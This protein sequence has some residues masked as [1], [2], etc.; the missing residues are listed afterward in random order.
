VGSLRYRVTFRGPGG[1]SWG[2]FGLANPHNALAG[3]IRHF[4]AAADAHTR[5]GPRTSYNVGRIGGGTSVNSIPFE[6]WM[7]VDMRS[8]DPA[9]LAVLDSDLQEG[10]GR[11][12][13]EENA[14]RR[15]GDSLTVQVEPVGSR[16]AGIL[17]P[18]ATPL[19]QR[20]LAVIRLR[21]REP[22]LG[23]GSTNANIPISLGVPAVGIG[24]GG[25]GG[26]NHSLDEWWLPVDAHLAVQNALLVV[27]AEGGLGG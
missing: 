15:R 25:R 7:E 16:P 27:L 13:M 12:L 9:S 5:Q 3:A 19:I 1:H 11:G 20:A 17:D 26:G 21:G 6:S 23:S 24:R 10:I 18:A 4:V 2:A 14:M 22:A 8:L